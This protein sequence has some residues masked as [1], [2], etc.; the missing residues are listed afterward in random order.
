MTGVSHADT[1]E[2]GLESLIVTAMV[3]TPGVQPLPE[4]GAIEATAPCRAR[5]GRCACRSS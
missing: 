4:Q 1:S 2:K 5:C 3:G